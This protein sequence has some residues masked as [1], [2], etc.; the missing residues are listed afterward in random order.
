MT[1]KKK[2]TL[3]VTWIDED[4]DLCKLEGVKCD[5]SSEELFLEIENGIVIPIMKRDPT[6][7]IK[8]I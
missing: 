6:L 7:E 3:V 1:T 2:N 8:K 4:G 5:E